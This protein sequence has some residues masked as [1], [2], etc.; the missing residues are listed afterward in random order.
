[1]SLTRIRLRNF[2]VFT[3]FDLEFPPGVNVFLGKNGAGKTHLMKVGYA[4]CA[5]ARNGE[6][7]A[8][9]LIRVFLPRRRH[10]GRLVTRR[11]GCQTSS[12]EVHRGTRRLRLEFAANSREADTARLKGGAAWQDDS[13][14]AVYI[15]VEEVLSHSLGLRY[16]QSSPDAGSP[17]FRTDLIEQALRTTHG[18]PMDSAREDILQEL[19]LFGRVRV[20][21]GEFYLDCQRGNLEFPLVADGL[22]K[23]GLLWLLVRNG[24][25]KRD[26]VLFWDHP[27]ASL[28]PS[29]FGSVMEALLKLQ[30]LGVQVFLATHDYVIL[31]ELELRRQQNDEVAFHTLFQGEDGLDTLCHT[32]RN[33]SGITPNAIAETFNSLYDRTIARDFADSFK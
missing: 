14:E 10:I 25:L 28:N 9:R 20:E 26:S 16:L 11:V 13:L 23:L 2:T 6:D 27:E 33:Y 12:V 17:D 31:K 22:R 7:F 3:D 1:M 4:A 15:P 29:L 5:A 8:E 30:R 19:R 21:S 24:T 18:V 32:S